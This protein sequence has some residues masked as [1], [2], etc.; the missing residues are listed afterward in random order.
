MPGVCEDVRVGGD[1]VQPEGS[2]MRDVADIVGW[3]WAYWKPISDCCVYCNRDAQGVSGLRHRV[4]RRCVAARWLPLHWVGVMLSSL[5]AD[6]VCLCLPGPQQR[7]YRCQNNAGGRAMVCRDC[8]D[9]W[10][11]VLMLFVMIIPKIDFSL[12]VVFSPA[13]CAPA[14]CAP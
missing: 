1:A 5:L 8:C 2:S 6:F 13:L 4:L 10:Q 12:F 7:L 3:R 9:H 14:L 11:V